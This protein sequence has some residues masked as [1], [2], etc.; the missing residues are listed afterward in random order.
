MRFIWLLYRLDFLLTHMGIFVTNKFF[1]NYR[2]DLSAKINVPFNLLA[3]KNRITQYYKLYVMLWR[4]TI[5]NGLA[6][7]YFLDHR[8]LKL[9][10]NNMF[11]QFWLL[12]EVFSFLYFIINITRHWINL[13]EKIAK[14][15]KVFVYAHI[16]NLLWSDFYQ[17]PINNA[18]QEERKKS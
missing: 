6:Q 8:G 2:S 3:C 9:L 4:D 7:Y 11:Q 1:S 17:V 10:F 14:K 18:W 13:G 16:P 12:L 15:I 5:F